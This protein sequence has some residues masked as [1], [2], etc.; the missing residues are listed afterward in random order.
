MVTIQ[1]VQNTFWIVIFTMI[2]AKLT[3]I[4]PILYRRGHS[5]G[6][7][8]MKKRWA[9]AVITCALS[10]V[11]AVPAFAGSWKY[12]NDQWKYQKGANKFAYDEWVEDQGG[13]YYIGNDGYMKTGWQQID[14][15]WYYLELETGKMQTGW[16]KDGTKWYFFYPNGVMAVNTVID[17]RK[18][19][20]DGVWIPEEGQ[21][22][23]SNTINISTPYL[24][25]N[26]QEGLNSR[27]YT[28]IASGRI[29]TGERWSNAIR[30]KGEGSYVQYDANGEYKLLCGTVAPSMQFP[31]GIMCKVVVYGDDSKVLYESPYIHYN[32][33]ISYF[34]VDVTGQNKVRVEIVPEKSGQWDQPIIL[35]DGLSLY[36]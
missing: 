11:M 29:S 27:D 6:E 28:I 14:G 17:G 20:A 13:S 36:K 7:K 25:Q 4:K 22:E 19:G 16:F 32:E 30:L 15:Q 5:K 3:N 8:F 24:V 33:K 12:I 18:I 10:A 31:S 35:I 34:G 1:M 23:P 2:E 9:V 21:A 26:M